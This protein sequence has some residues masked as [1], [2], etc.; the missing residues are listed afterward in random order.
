MKL[1][2]SFAP[3]STLHALRSTSRQSGS[4]VIVIMALL[5]ILLLYMAYNIKTLA[6]LGRELRLLERQQTHRLQSAAPKT[7]SPPAVIIS[8]NS[9][10]QPRTN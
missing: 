10:S 5:A 6:N 8:T 2:R 7:N 4:A 1:R 3:R 9:I